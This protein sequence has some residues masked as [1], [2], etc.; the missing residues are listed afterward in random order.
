METGTRR[1]FGHVGL[2]MRIVLG[3]AVMDHYMRL[4]VVVAASII[5]NA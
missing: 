4:V 2:S 5:N 3:R 1:W